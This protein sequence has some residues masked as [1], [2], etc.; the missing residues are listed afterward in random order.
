[1]GELQQWRCAI[2][3]TEDPGGKGGLHIDH[4]H[5]H[6]AGTYGCGL[7]YRGL[8]CHS[9]NTGLG[10][11]RENPELLDAAAAYIRMCE[12]QTRI[13]DLTP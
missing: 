10:L 11:F 5:R 2:C 3:R 9:C 1:M 13:W 6:C 4:D 7:C 12:Y 8:L